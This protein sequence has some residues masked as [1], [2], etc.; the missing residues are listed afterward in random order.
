MFASLEGSA[1]TLR[2]KE[3]F[4]PLLAIAQPMRS[5][6]AQPMRSPIAQPMRSHRH[7]ELLLSSHGLL[8]GTAPY[9]PFAL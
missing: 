5:P 2:L 8:F 6:I 4:F 9:L 3:D 1:T 7:P